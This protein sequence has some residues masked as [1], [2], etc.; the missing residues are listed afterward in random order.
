MFLTRLVCFLS[1][2]L[3]IFCPLSIHA[4]SVNDGLKNNPE[5]RME[6]LNR[7]TGS[8]GK[9]RCQNPLMP[10]MSIGEL[11]SLLN[12]EANEGWKIDQVVN[13]KFFHV[14][15]VNGDFLGSY[16]FRF[17]KSNDKDRLNLSLMFSEQD[18]KQ[19]LNSVLIERGHDRNAMPEFRD[20]CVWE[21]LGK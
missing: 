3:V 4:D 17:L 5:G 2:P 7:L 8:E 15:V 6:L 9:F 10:V 11:K 1:I 13:T 18:S 20:L 12:F 21:A 14:P 16:Q 19:G